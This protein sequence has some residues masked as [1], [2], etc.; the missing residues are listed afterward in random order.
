[1]NLHNTVS[2][3][4]E[5]KL[6]CKHGNTSIRNQTAYVTVFSFQPQSNCNSN[7][8]PETVQSLI[9]PVILK[10]SIKYGLVFWDDSV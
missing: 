10:Q 8:L 7:S 6:K 1:M 4:Y 9:V 2:H 3:N 5:F